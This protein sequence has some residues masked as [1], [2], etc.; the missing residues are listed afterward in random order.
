MKNYN[1]IISQLLSFFLLLSLLSCNSYDDTFDGG[2]IPL[3]TESDMSKIHGNS[4]KSWQITKIINDYY[5][6]IYHLEIELSCLVDD[7]YTFSS[8]TNEFSVNLGD[9][10]CFGTNEDGIFTADVEIFDGEL[11]FMDASNGET[12]YLR[13]SR[14]YM[15]ADGTAQG[16]SIRYYKLA[17]LSET[18]M[19]FYRE[20][21]K[22]GEYT[23][24]IIFDA[25]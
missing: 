6:P 13:Y 23:Q 14:G 7:V 24:A 8:T 18:R 9:D 10:K 15:N 4:E 22:F 17:E 25:I 20:K 2:N 21:I 12:I 3:F 19:V 5:D 1:N 16:I 11:V